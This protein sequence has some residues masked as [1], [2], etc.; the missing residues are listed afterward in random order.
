[1]SKD[2]YNKIKVL[3]DEGIAN[4]AELNGAKRDYIN[5]KTEIEALENSINGINASISELKTSI[6]E[7]KST[8]RTNLRSKKSDLDIRI[9]N[10]ESGLAS[11][12]DN[13]SRR[14]VVSPIDGIIKQLKV[15]PLAK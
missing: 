10:I 3:F 2:Y 1:M 15:K 6:E 4:E 11:V 8:F 9:K 5:V 13:L 12:E 7:R 14:E